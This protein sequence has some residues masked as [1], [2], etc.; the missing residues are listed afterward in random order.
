MLITAIGIITVIVVYST[1]TFV[2][3][4]NDRHMLR[5]LPENNMLKIPPRTS[6]YRAI[7]KN[8]TANCSLSIFEVKPNAL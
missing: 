6:P 4:V 7:L 5:V 2:I 3:P 1:T 8:L